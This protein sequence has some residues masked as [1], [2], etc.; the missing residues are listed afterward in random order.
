MVKLIEKYMSR[1]AKYVGA[2][3]V[4]LTCSVPASAQDYSEGWYQI[5]RTINIGSIAD[6]DFGSVSLLSGVSSLMSNVAY[7][8][9]G[10][11]FTTN[12]TIP[13][14][15]INIGSAVYGAGLMD[16]DGTKDYSYDLISSNGKNANEQYLTT[17]YYI[18]PVG[19][20]DDG[21]WRYTVRSV[22]GH[23]MGPDGRY[24][25]EPKEVYFNSSLGITLGS[26]LDS[27]LNSLVSM[28][29][30]SVGSKQ[31]TLSASYIENIPYIDRLEIYSQI[32]PLIEALGDLGIKIST[33]SWTKKSLTDGDSEV[34]YIGTTEMLETL[35]SMAQDAS[36]LMNYYNDGDYASLGC[37]LMKYVGLD[38]F[39]LKKV[40]LSNIATTSGIFA[41][42]TSVTPYAV[43]LYAF[44]DNFSLNE[45]DYRTADSLTKLAQ[46]TNQ[47]AMVEYAGSDA[48]AN[49]VIRFYNG[50]TLFVKKG[51]AVGD[52]NEIFQLVTDNG[53][54]VVDLSHGQY[55]TLVDEASQAVNL[56]I[57]S[58]KQGEVLGIP[59]GRWSD[60][61]KTVAL[62]KSGITTLWSP[63]DLVI[64]GDEKGLF[65]SI[66]KHAPKAYVASY[67]SDDD[68]N[69]YCQEL[70]NTIPA[71]TPVIIK[72]DASQ[73]YSFTVSETEGAATVSTD[74]DSSASSA[75]AYAAASDA[76]LLQGTFVDYA[77]PADLLAYQ[78]KVDE[79]MNP[80]LTLLDG[81]NRVIPAW[82]AYYIATPTDDEAPASISVVLDGS[83]AA[84]ENVAVDAAQSEQQPT[85]IYDICGRRVPTG[86]LRPGLYIIN[87]VKTVIR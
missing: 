61:Y 70:L 83:P 25:V 26:A 6:L 15:S 30:V 34:G 39:K 65:G 49:S 7:L 1:L 81:E 69:V 44:G 22:N 62:D 17:Y 68:D 31:Y 76:N 60:N 71:N 46:K 74:A 3:A 21:E 19:A 87:G 48:Q 18:T 55:V 57:S 37:M 47:N 35:Q 50:G 13:V 28:L 52:G 75:P 45:M 40:N 51:G 10:E 59:T 43:N 79:E 23:Y 16:V 72:G 58:P 54:D 38:L 41:K 11:E 63:F 80:V 36:T 5:K 66:K 32:Q 24:Y 42:H 8:N 82:Q 53:T 78:L 12:V 77:V 14:V 2:A 33:N 29:G 64:P 20:D 85:E 56:I 86:N 84:I 4:A 9:T 27:T 67:R 73:S